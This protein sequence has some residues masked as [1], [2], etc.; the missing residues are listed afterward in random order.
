MTTSI[1]IRLT[2]QT[3]AMS[4]TKFWKIAGAGLVA[5][6]VASGLTRP[7]NAVAGPGY[8]P[9]RDV[10]NAII[11]PFAQE[12]SWFENNTANAGTFTVAAGKRLEITAIS[13]YTFVPSGTNVYVTLQATVGG[14]SVTHR[15]GLLTKDPTLGTGFFMLPLLQVNLFADPGTVVSLVVRRDVQP[16]TGTSW[17]CDFVL[18]G[19][20]VNQ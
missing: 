20:L 14:T 2:Q 16:S 7:T 19:R 6:C 10:D 4:K 1:L 17:Y 15:L 18:T 12:V 13:G 11:N 3:E 5:A 9:V 8:T